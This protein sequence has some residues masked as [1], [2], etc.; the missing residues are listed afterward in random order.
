MDNI[1]EH[2]V[3]FTTD[4]YRS[5]LR[6]ASDRYQ[7]KLFDDHDDSDSFIIWRHDVDMSPHRALTL[8]AIEQEEKVK[9]TYFFYDHSVFYNLF[10]KGV[11]EIVRKILAMGHSIGIHF[12]PVFYDIEDEKSLE[13]WLAFERM[14]FETIFNVPITCF[15]F[16]CTTRFTLAAN[17]DTYAG[18]IN[19]TSQF[20]R[21]TVG[22]CSDSSGYWR[23]DRLEDVLREGKHDRLQVLT[24]PSHW[25][26]KIMSP[27]Q[28]YRRC[29]EGR[30]RATWTDFE[31][32]IDGF[33]RRLLD[34]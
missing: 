17:K 3:D 21:E 9:S 8:A 5:L 22:Y 15:S 13:Y 7:F 25:Q 16:H 11:T 30:A 14:Q 23:F 31:A 33:G 2:S 18:L 10:E 20:F 29:I 4:N 28:R 24:H 12:D 34:D 26:E 32:I 6:L 19:A 27:V 1:H